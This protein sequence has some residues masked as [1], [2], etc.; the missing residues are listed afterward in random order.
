MRARRVMDSSVDSVEDSDEAS[1]KA[2]WARAC[3]RRAGA[4]AFEVRLI[5][6]KPRRRIARHLR[7]RRVLGRSGRFL[8]EGG[9]AAP[10]RSGLIRAR[11]TTDQTTLA[12]TT[13]TSTCPASTAGLPSLSSSPFD[14]IADWPAEAALLAL[15]TI[16]A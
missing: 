12:C 4:V 9:S 5:S 14:A 7:S 11:H 2:D 6:A 16:S 1:S 3:S 13:W 8:V 15:L 10:L